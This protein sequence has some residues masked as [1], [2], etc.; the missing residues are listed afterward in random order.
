MWGKWSP[1]VQLSLWTAVREVTAS[2][3]ECLTLIREGLHTA[4]GPGDA[5][6]GGFNPR[7]VNVNVPLTDVAEALRLCL[8]LENGLSVQGDKLHRMFAR[9]VRIDVDFPFADGVHKAS[10]SSRH[11]SATASTS[12]LGG[13]SGRR[14]SLFPDSTAAAGS[15]SSAASAHG[16]ASA[17]TVSSAAAG[18]S[19]PVASPRLGP[20]NPSSGSGSGI[21]GNKF[22]VNNN[23]SNVNASVAGTVGAGAGASAG[24]G[25]SVVGAAGVP[26]LVGVSN[27]SLGGSSAAFKSVFS[28]TTASSEPSPDAGLHFRLAV[29]EF[30]GVDMPD[31]WHVGDVVLQ[32]GTAEVLR[33][34]QG[35]I[36][37]VQVEYWNSHL[38]VGSWD[39]LRVHG[40][41][42][43]RGDLASC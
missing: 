43:C 11:V 20:F 3:W 26:P 15:S 40:R 13:R 17:P 29:G 41:K 14:A 25:A 34:R 6:G 10:S 24:G 9:N 27:R 8:L 32:L 4:R 33:V 35:N 19:S 31:S 30:S 28:P 23:G 12:S 16:M 21:G 22:N 39:L 5:A 37:V 36:L 1:V 38:G 7:N 18:V 42:G 2:V